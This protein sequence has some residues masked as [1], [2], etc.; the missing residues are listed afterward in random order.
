MSELEAMKTELVRAQSA[1]QQYEAQVQ[2]LQQQMQAM[3]TQQQTQS[4][5]NTHGLLKPLKPSTFDGGNN[6]GSRVDTW[7]FELENF[8]RMYPKLTDAE[9]IAFA[10]AC[11]RDGAVIWWRAIVQSHT[12]EEQK[13]W[14]YTQFEQAIRDQYQP[15]GAAISARAAL[16]HLKQNGSVNAYSAVFMRH[17]NAISHKMLKEDQMYL[18]KQGLQAQL[19]REVDM[20]NPTSLNECMQIAQRAEI[21]QRQFQRARGLPSVPRFLPANGSAPMEVAAIDTES[22]GEASLPAHPYGWPMSMVPYGYPPWMQ[23]ARV[24]GSAQKSTS[25]NSNSKQETQT[26]LESSLNAVNMNRSPSMDPKVRQD[27]LQK[28]LCFR[29]KQHGHLSRN[30]PSKNGQRQ[31]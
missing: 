18:Y 7:L 27:C 1:A 11:L 19:A 6:A 3:Q 31:Q 29:C 15:V 21:T 17:L 16:H 9:K 12:A 23:P 25:N 28:G 5:V 4:Q 8:F 20:H 30:C 26:E 13:N 2:A 10:V 14:S 22:Y 24:S